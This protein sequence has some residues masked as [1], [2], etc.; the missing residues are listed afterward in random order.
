MKKKEKRETRSA[1]STHRGGRVRAGHARGPKQAEA[2]AGM[3][4]GISPGAQR[5][6]K[7][8]VQEPR[9]E[10]RKHPGP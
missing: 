1:L 10:Q 2:R 3:G 8:S 9:N 4:G 6:A 5:P 7:A